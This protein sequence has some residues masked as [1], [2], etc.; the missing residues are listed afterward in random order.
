MQK[1]DAWHKILAQAS[2]NLLMINPTRITRLN[3]PLTNLKA[4][5][6]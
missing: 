6:S 3:E 4:H 1:K 5:P 2:S